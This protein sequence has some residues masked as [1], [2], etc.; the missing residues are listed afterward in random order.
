MSDIQSTLCW[1]GNNHLCTT[2]SKWNGA[3]VSTEWAFG[4]RIDLR[5]RQEAVKWN[6]HF[7]GQHQSLWVNSTAKI[8]PGSWVLNGIS[9][10]AEWWL[11]SR[12]NEIP[13]SGKQDP[14][15]GAS[16]MECGRGWWSLG[17]GRFCGPVMA[18]YQVLRNVFITV[19][20]LNFH[21][22]HT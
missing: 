1:A 4:Q 15:A 18:G 13:F 20:L 10:D 8:S 5:W 2:N 22:K 16:W 9:Q 19:R 11:G 3:V 14:V 6:W 17:S 21:R 7:P 12:P